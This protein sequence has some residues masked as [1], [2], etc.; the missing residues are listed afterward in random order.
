MDKMPVLLVYDDQNYDANWHRHVR[1][2]VRSV[3]VRGSEVAM[4]KSTTKGFYQ[5]PGG[6][7]D[8]GETHE[9]ALIRETLEEV[10]LTVIPHT[11]RPLG[12]VKEIRASQFAAET[13]FDQ[14]SYYYFARVEDEVCKQVLEDYE[15]DLGY[16]LEWVDMNRARQNN[17]KLCRTHHY[18]SKFVLREAE[19]LGLLLEHDE[20]R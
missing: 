5:F 15:K 14:T 1:H 3:I 8:S 7:V 10:G 2:A 11:I 18:K 19:I 9:Q 6:G 17:L 12:I 16:T 4:V 13:I 20:L